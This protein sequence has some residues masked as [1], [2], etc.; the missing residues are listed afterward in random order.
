MKPAPVERFDKYASSRKSE[1][2]RSD[3]TDETTDDT[4]DGGSDEH[5]RRTPS[6]FVALRGG[7]VERTTTASRQLLDLRLQYVGC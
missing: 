1:R 7:E 5:D 3:L 2:K 4:T 6:E